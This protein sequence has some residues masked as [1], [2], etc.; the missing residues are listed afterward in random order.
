I[1]QMWGMPMHHQWRKE[2]QSGTLAGPRMVIASPI[3]D[4]PNAI[5]QGSVS[6]ATEAQARDAVNKARLDGADF[7][8]IYTRLTRDA[9]FAI[10][11]ETRRLG[12]PFAGHVPQAVTVAEASDAGQ[13]SIEHLTGILMACSSREDELRKELASAASA[14]PSQFS[15]P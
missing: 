3:V 4:G 9:F 11:D 13:K 8:K 15:S 7:I 2:Q 1:R 12:I 5:W 14:N 10:A 6:V